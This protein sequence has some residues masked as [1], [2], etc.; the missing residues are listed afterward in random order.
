[1]PR[2]VW[3]VRIRPRARLRAHTP[4]PRDDL[5]KLS[6]VR[7]EGVGFHAHAPSGARHGLPARASAG[8]WFRCSRSL[9]A[10]GPRLLG[11]ARTEVLRLC[12]AAL[13]LCARAQAQR[14]RTAPPAATIRARRCRAWLLIRHPRAARRLGRRRRGCQHQAASSSIVHCSLDFGACRADRARRAHS[15]ARRDPRCVRYGRWPAVQRGGRLSA[16]RPQSAQS[17]RE[18]CRV[19]LVHTHC[20]CATAV[21][22]MITRPTDFGNSYVRRRLVRL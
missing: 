7:C 21:V 2:A 8:R 22:R 19:S 13:P 9:H 10:L 20:A 18:T 6:K 14:S 4:C 3:F 15:I 16:A 12:A 5:R 17:H 1:M 11:S